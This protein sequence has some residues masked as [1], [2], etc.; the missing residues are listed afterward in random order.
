MNYLYWD[1]NRDS[2]Y[3]AE[4]WDAS[5]TPPR[6]PGIVLPAAVYISVTVYAGQV[7]LD[8]VGPDEPMETMTASTVVD[9][10][11][12]LHDPRYESV[13]ARQ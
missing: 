13:R 5:T 1:V 11:S 6:P 7:P 12:V 3:W 2:P 9:L 4:E 8:Q 10:E